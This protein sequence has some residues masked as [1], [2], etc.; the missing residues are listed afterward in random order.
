MI[1]RK[2]LDVGIGTGGE[3]IRKNH[4]TTLRIGLDNSTDDLGICFR[5]YGIPVVRADAY[6]DEGKLLPFGDSSFDKIEVYFPLDELLHGLATSTA[7]WSE[8]G[9]ILKNDGSVSVIIDIPFIG[10]QGYCVGKERKLLPNPDSEIIMRAEEAGFIVSL[11]ELDAETV[12]GIGT[13]FAEYVASQQEIP[14]FCGRACEIQAERNH[15]FTPGVNYVDAEK[16]SI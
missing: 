1:E 7:L 2:I 10:I 6:V 16:L 11:K 9:R 12:R 3:Y 15:E 8:F 5:K 14:I 13:R 4:E